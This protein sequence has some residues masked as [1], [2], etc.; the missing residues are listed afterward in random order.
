MSGRIT[1]AAALLLLGGG[2][3]AVHLPQIVNRPAGPTASDVEDALAQGRAMYVGR[4]YGLA[5]ALFRTAI[6]LAPE[7]ADGYDGLAA[8]YDGLGRFDLSRHYY[9]VA[10]AFAPGNP[11]IYRNLAAS[12]K[13]Q[14]RAQ[15]ADAVLAEAASLPDILAAPRPEL[16]GSTGAGAMAPPRQEVS[17]DLDTVPA[18]ALPEGAGRLIAMLE[19]SPLLP[20]PAS[21][22]AGRAV[23]PLRIF[24]ANGGNGLAARAR[25]RLAGTAW[26][27]A[28]I[29]NS[30]PRP[31]SEIVYPT[32]M[33]VAA[34]SV[35]ARIHFPVRLRES[36][37]T[38]WVTLWIG[39]DA[40]PARAMGAMG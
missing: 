17:L 5:I 30:P 13:A 1:A 10:L 32:G 4:E 35:R 19:R 12:L 24:N 31:H 3:A 11:R 29:A 27:R 7:R 36:A 40:T 38:P 25:G 23:P 20:A 33:A 22:V 15:E 37:V 26:E 8:C 21:T 6:R 39:A 2:C 28:I 34:Q 16:A 14:G 9:E 18:L